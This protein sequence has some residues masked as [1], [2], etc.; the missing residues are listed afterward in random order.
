MSI[1][2]KFILLWY[3][4]NMKIKILGVLH[5]IA[6]FGAGE[7]VHLAKDFNQGSKIDLNSSVS[8]LKHFV[9]IAGNDNAYSSELL[10]IDTDQAIDIGRA[11]NSAFGLVRF[12]SNQL[13]NDDKKD[14]ESIYS[15]AANA[16][17]KWGRDTGYYIENPESLS[18]PFF[19]FLKGTNKFEAERIKQL[20]KIYTG[21]LDKDGSHDSPINY[22]T[23]GIQSGLTKQEI[24]EFFTLS[25]F[26]A[27][28]NHL[29]RES[30]RINSRINAIANPTDSEIKNQALD[31]R[32]NTAALNLIKNLKAIKESMVALGKVI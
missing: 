4:H 20:L 14:I 8:I 28:Q 12:K 1:R 16:A 19:S 26:E 7:F 24:V 9:E 18:Y 27:M 17:I 10:D 15:Q 29:N 23:L 11:L 5:S 13:N 30:D 3:S 6:I 32:Q 31:S 22:I 21:A 2:R 25:D